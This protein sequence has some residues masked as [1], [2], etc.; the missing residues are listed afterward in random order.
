MDLSK[1]ISKKKWRDI[2]GTIQ[3][4]PKRKIKKF[5]C[6]YRKYHPNHLV[7]MNKLV[8]KVQLLKLQHLYAEANP[9]SKVNQKAK[10]LNTQLRRHQNKQTLQCGKDTTSL[11]DLCSAMY[12]PV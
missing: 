12:G 4:P 11:L 6:D 8:A 3:A 10:L 2:D 1:F 7:V 5:L 9:V